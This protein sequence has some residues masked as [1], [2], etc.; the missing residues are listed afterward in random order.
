LALSSGI[1]VEEGEQSV[2]VHFVIIE[3]AAKSPILN[4]PFMIHCPH[5]TEDVLVAFTGIST[6]TVGYDSMHSELGIFAFLN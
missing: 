4:I 2:E 6:L 3:A 5:V 1:V